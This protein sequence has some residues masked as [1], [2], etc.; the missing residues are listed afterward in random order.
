MKLFSSRVVI[1]LL[2]GLASEHDYAQALS[3]QQG[4]NVASLSELVEA[5]GMRVASRK[6]ERPMS[7]YYD[8]LAQEDD[9]ILATSYQPDDT[10]NL[11]QTVQNDDSVN[12]AQLM[13]SV[14]KKY[15]EAPKPTDH[16]TTPSQPSDQLTGSLSQ[17]GSSSEQKSASASE[18]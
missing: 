16:V 1:L 6:V 15:K 7:I 3:I 13:S 5:A 14:L 8:Q 12:I 9:D 11:Q 2:L 10:K 17:S 4:S 18:S